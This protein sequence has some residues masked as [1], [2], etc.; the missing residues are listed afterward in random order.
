MTRIATM[1]VAVVVFVV[2]TIVGVRLLV[3][4]TEAAEPTAGCRASVVKAGTDLNSNVVRVNVFNASTR[5]GLANRVTINLQANGFLGGQIG[6]S[7][8][9]A[10][11]GRVAILT[12]NRDDPRVKLVAAQF[13]DKVTYAELDI[14]VP[15]GVTVVVGNNFS[16]LKSKAR[17]S[18][19][20]DR[21]IRVCV[22]VVPLP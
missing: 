4:G 13:R 5:S 2:G 20:T 15:G 3:S 6:N 7:T 11:P 17:T 12:P 9:Q 10:T 16:G 19:K 8:S 22:P 21:D 18:V 14:E 1:A